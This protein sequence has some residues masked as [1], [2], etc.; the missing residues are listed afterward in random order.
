M[1]K[2]AIFDNY[3]DISGTLSIS[4]DVHVSDKIVTSDS[5]STVLNIHGLD[6]PPIPTDPCGEA[7]TVNSSGDGLEWVSND[8]IG[9]TTSNANVSNFY[10]NACTD[11]TTSESLAKDGGDN[12]FYSS[13]LS[14]LGIN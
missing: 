5:N 9:G 11:V 8:A 4:G 12:I 3:I 2:S 13:L 14:T 7:L 1:S 10:E 6:I